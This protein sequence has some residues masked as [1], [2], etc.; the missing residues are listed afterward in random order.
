MLTSCSGKSITWKHTDLVIFGCC[1]QEVVN[2]V[3]G[4]GC[5]VNVQLQCHLGRSVQRR[6]LISGSIDLSMVG[7]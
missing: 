6:A 5:E 2:W 7:G 3:G 1:G 4:V